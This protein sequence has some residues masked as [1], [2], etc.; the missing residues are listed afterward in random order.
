MFPFLNRAITLR[1]EFPALDNLVLY[2]REREQWKV[3]AITA[4]VRKMNDTLKQST[5]GLHQVVT[6]AGESQ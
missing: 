3:D 4:Q 5:A 1:V 6:K 2:L